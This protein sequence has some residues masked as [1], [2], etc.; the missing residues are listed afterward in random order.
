[1]A[2]QSRHRKPVRHAA[3]KPRPPRIP[4]QTR[5]KIELERVTRHRE[6]RH[7]NQNAGGK[8]P[9]PVKL[10]AEQKFGIRLIHAPPDI[11]GPA[12]ESDYAHGWRF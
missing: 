7:E 5:P 6:G 2:E 10:A 11:R 4:Q 3:D 9:V 8:S 12:P 1:M